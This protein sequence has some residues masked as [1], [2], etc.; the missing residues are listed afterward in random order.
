[1]PE[2]AQKVEPMNSVN[3]AFS[4]ALRLWVGGPHKWR[5]VL[6]A[7]W[8]FNKIPSRPNFD[9]KLNEERDVID[10]DSDTYGN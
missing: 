4:P 7:K 3:P 1:M 9:N 10:S 5:L 6:E 2:C 8:L